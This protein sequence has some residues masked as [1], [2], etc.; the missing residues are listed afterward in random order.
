MCSLLKRRAEV[1]PRVC[2]GTTQSNR[3]AQISKG[4]SPRVRGNHSRC[5]VRATG[6]RSIPACAGEPLPTAF[7]LPTSKVYPRVCGGTAKLAAATRTAEGLSPR[8]RGNRSLLNAS[9]IVKRSI[10]ACAGEPCLRWL[11]LIPTEVYPRVCGGTTTPFQL[12]YPVSG[13][14][15]RVRGNRQ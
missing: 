11:T 3:S 13:L 12:N 1:Y 10:P 7:S 6:N 4:L 8:V 15:P 5:A 9:R 2:G 14:S